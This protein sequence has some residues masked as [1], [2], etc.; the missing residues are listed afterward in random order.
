MLNEDEQ[1]M[2]FTMVKQKMKQTADELCKVQE[3]TL[4]KNLMKEVRSAF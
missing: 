4:F 2:I 3:Y 1:I